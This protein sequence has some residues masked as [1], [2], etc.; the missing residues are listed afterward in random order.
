M[1]AKFWYLAEGDLLFDMQQWASE[2]QKRLNYIQYGTEWLP[3]EE[4]PLTIPVKEPTIDD[5]AKSFYNDNIKEARKF[6]KH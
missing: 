5:L 6:R 4:Q 1:R 3:E 2:A